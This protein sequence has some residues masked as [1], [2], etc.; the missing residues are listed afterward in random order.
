MGIVDAE[1]ARGA[2]AIIERAMKNLPIILKLAATNCHLSAL[3]VLM[4]RK[5]FTEPFRDLRKVAWLVWVAAVRSALLAIA[6]ILR[7]LF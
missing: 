4:G 7:R 3:N 6:H 2:D 5:T 1:H